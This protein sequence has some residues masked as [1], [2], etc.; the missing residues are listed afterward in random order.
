MT[1][2]GDDMSTFLARQ[3]V[4]AEKRNGVIQELER[5][6]TLQPDSQ[7]P[8]RDALAKLL[9]LVKVAR[10]MQAYPRSSK[11]LRELAEAI[12]ALEPSR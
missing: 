3:A 8:T 2:G 1:S 10:R 12:K 9:V 6:V 5:Y 7:P 4:Y 11:A